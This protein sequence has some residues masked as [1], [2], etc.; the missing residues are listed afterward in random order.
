MSEF[1]KDFEAIEKFRKKTGIDPDKIYMEIINPTSPLYQ[2]TKEAQFLN[3]QA[4]IL[5]ELT[6]AVADKVEMFH[7]IKTILKDAS[8]VMKKNM[9]HLR[10]IKAE[11]YEEMKKINELIDDNLDRLANIDLNKD[12]EI[13][14]DLMK[15]IK[16]VYES[17]IILIN[18]QEQGEILGEKDLVQ[19]IKQ[20]ENIVEF[21]KEIVK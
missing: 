18:K 17:T 1:K 11:N 6:N 4:K 19:I 8:F 5:T 13:L 3:A 15:T 14:G 16:R 7:D 9:K 21:P 10:D 2:K 20:I 12:T